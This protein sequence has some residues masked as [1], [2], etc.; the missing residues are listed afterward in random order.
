MKTHVFFILFL[1][2]LI[3]NLAIPLGQ[4]S[5]KFFEKN[6]GKQQKE[7]N[8]KINLFLQDIQ[9]D[10]NHTIYCPI[11]E[12]IVNQGEAYISKNTSEQEAIKFLDHLCEELPTSKQNKCEEFVSHNFEQLYEFII[13]KE[14]AQLV[15]SQLHICDAIDVQ[16]SVSECDFCRYAVHKVETFL[17]FNNTLN[18]IIEYG[19]MFCR[20]VRPRYKKQC[21]YVIPFYYSQIVAKLVDHHNFVNACESLHLCQK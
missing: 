15:C 18:D 5:F 17:H 16:K 2:A 1:T 21:D 8:E 19:E 7:N 6:E 10:V 9:K 12:F 14:S 4:E 20:G 13:D 3:G 11:C